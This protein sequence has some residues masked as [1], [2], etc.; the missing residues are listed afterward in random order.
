MCEALSG[1]HDPAALHG[2]RVEQEQDPYM[3]GRWCAWGI[4]GHLPNKVGRMGGVWKEAP[5]THSYPCIRAGNVGNCGQSFSMAAVML[6][7]SWQSLKEVFILALSPF[8]FTPA[9]A[10]WSQPLSQGQSQTVPEMGEELLILPDV[11]WFRFFFQTVKGEVREKLGQALS[12]PLSRSWWRKFSLFGSPQGWSIS[13]P[14]VPMPTESLTFLWASLLGCYSTAGR[15]GVLHCWGNE[16]WAGFPS[17]ALGGSEARIFLLREKPHWSRNE[18]QGR[19]ST[20]GICR[21]KSQNKWE[22]TFTRHFPHSK[23]H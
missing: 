8:Q 19:V 4:K 21:T 10:I 7:S 16:K 12:E 15:Q 1:W 22:L 5:A 14:R 13:E 2:P 6:G 11:L 23:L 9:S 20:L 3:K 17:L 18:D